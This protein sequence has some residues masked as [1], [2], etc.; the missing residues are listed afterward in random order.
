[1]SNFCQIQSLQRCRLTFVNAV[2]SNNESNVAISKAFME[3]KAAM[4]HLSLGLKDSIFDEY[5]SYALASPKATPGRKPHQAS[6]EAERE[7]I[8][9]E[10]DGGSGEGAL[11]D[12]VSGQINERVGRAE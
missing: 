10:E 7:W 4:E 1:M 12:E 8:C 3:F 11:N 5:I 2:G 9:V 6:L